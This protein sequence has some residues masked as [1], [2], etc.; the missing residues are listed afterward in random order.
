MYIHSSSL[1]SVQTMHSSMLTTSNNN[2]IR[3]SQEHRTRLYQ[4]INE[5]ND[6]QLRSF[7]TNH[8]QSI[9][10]TLLNN[11]FQHYS[12][13]Q[14]IQQSYILID[15][16]Y[17]VDLEQTLYAMRQKRFPNEYRQTYRATPPPPLTQQQ[18]NYTASYNQQQQQ[19][20]Y[21]YTQQPMQYNV[22]PNYRFHPPTNVSQPLRQIRPN[23]TS[24]P[25]ATVHNHQPQNSRPQQATYFPSLAPRQPYVQ[26]PPTSTAS[27]NGSTTTNL[28]YQ[29]P[30]LPPPPPPSTN[31]RTNP[32]PPP[33]SSSS[34]TTYKITHKTLP[35][36]RPISCIYESYQGFRYDTYRK[37]YFYRG[38][39]LLSCEVCNQLGLSYDYDADLD[40]HKTTKCLIMRLVRLDQPAMSNGKYDDNLPPNLVVQINSH[41]LTN[42]PI[43][44]PC[45]RQQTDLIRIGREI[46][47]T[48]YCMFNPEM[49]NDFS[50][51]WSYRPEN[52]VLHSQYGN[53]QYA[54]HIFL[55]QHLTIE[56][57]CEQIQH[58]T[59]RFYREDL[60]KLVAK[61][62]A[63]DHDLGL[64]VSD[65]KLKLKCP[66]D[67]RR[68]RIPIRATTCQHLQCFDLT[69]YIALNEKA[70]KWICPVCNKSALF[71][72][73]QIDSYTE[74][75]LKSMENEAIDE[76]SIDS[77]LNWKPITL[78][79]T[80][81]TFE[82][83]NKT[84]DIHDIILDD[85]MEDDDNYQQHYHQQIDSKSNIQLL[86]STTKEPSD[87]IL[88]DDD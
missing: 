85:E 38:D 22:Q 19:Q 78:S 32:P 33:P 60:A 47:I 63:I 18:Q 7:L 29:V 42:L 27:T 82:H 58:K 48:S 45:T 73:L 86:P 53:A 57:L 1:N 20:P 74:S 5:L 44:K 41:N 2:T 17:S 68:L 13:T 71:D 35:F 8:L 84:A 88:I 11:Q 10:T 36:Y 62:L 28:R 9:T 83:Q 40:I 81:L 64:E 43:P 54:F 50:V 76:I 79:S 16:Y 61:A 49:K 25:S 26:P 65:Q 4:I 80:S 39:F 46:D 75:I 66:I 24:V 72:D 34:T 21:Y 56:D 69:N 70:G 12:R 3:L 67:Q 14:L 87:I 52:T 37:H 51:T 15:N 23:S 31:T 59:A 77:N 6:D 55:V 30:I